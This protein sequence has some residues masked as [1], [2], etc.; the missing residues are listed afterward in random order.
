M[1][2]ITGFLW[3]T[4]SG[5]DPERVLKTM[6]KAIDHRGPDSDGHWMDPQAGVAFGHVRL[7]IVDLS[8][9]GHQPMQSASQRYMLT[10][11]GEIYNHQKLRAQLEATGHAPDWRGTS[12]TETLLACIDAWGLRKTLEQC[13]GMFALGLWDAKN[14]VLH[15]ARD[16]FGEKPLYYGWQGTG[17]ERAFLFGSELKALRAHP[18]FEGQIARS[19]LVDCLRHGNVGEDRCIYDGIAKLRAGRIITIDQQTG[20]EQIE[21]YWDAAEIAVRPKPQR[22][23]DTEVTDALEGLLSDAIGQQMMSDVPLGAFLSGGIDSS[24]VVAMM[25]ALSDRPVHTFSIGF[26]EARYNEAEFA[27]AV[28]D[29]LGTKHTDLYV[30]DKELLDVVPQLPHMYDEPFADSSQ[31]PTYLVSKLAREHVTVSLSGDG[32]D[33]LFGGYGRYVHAAK[34]RAKL[35]KMPHSLRQMGAGAIR[36]LPMPVLNKLLGGIFPTPQGKEPIG[37]RLHRLA[38][39]ARQPD[40]ETLHRTM[41]SNWRFPDSGVLNAEPPVSLLAE[42]LPPRGDL[43]EIERMMQLDMAT[44]M[45]DDILA[46]VDRATMAVALES[47]APLLDHRIAE[48]AWDLPLDQKVRGDQTKWALRQVLYRHVPKE[49][50]ERP[51]M[52]FEVPIGLWLRSSL[53]EWGADLLHPDRLNRDGYFDTALIKGMWDQHQSGQ[54]NWGAQLWNVLMIQAWLEDTQ[55]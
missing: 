24:V 26:S 48:F 55:A 25:Q 15:M 9:A 53:R 47:R 4:G 33:E 13:I 41:V 37:Q 19:S 44:Y 50:I 6:T 42:A 28:A 21:T 16:R 7:A 34:L 46:K 32:G 27:R 8:A 40:L 31:I 45:I 43:S 17:A 35:Q 5:P 49:L 54:C 12:D 10:F 29:H 11:N 18:A 39:Y 38:N 30:S 22:V 36:A 14:R 2:G 51:K 20:S 1:C 52:G 3:S 23:S